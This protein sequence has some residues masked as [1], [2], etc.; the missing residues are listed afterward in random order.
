MSSLWLHRWHTSTKSVIED[1]HLSCRRPLTDRCGSMTR[2]SYLVTRSATRPKWS[3]K[4]TAETYSL[5]SLNM[6]TAI[7]GDILYNNINQTLWMPEGTLKSLAIKNQETHVIKNKTDLFQS[8]Q[9]PLKVSNK[10]KL[11]I[12]NPHIQTVHP[13]TWNSTL[14]RGGGGAT[15]LFSQWQWSKNMSK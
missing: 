3:E 10:Q 12:G 6:K 13:I 11:T 4:C 1:W 7:K 8:S 2:D 9:L 14:T 5:Y 15:I